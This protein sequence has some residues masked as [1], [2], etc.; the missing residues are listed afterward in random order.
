MSLIIPSFDE[1]LKAAQ[2]IAEAEEPG[3]VAQ[4]IVSAAEN[5][6]GADFATIW[7][8]D[9]DSGKFIP[10]E[11]VAS[12][13]SEKAKEEFRSIEPRPNHLTY[14]VLLKQII[15]IEDVDAGTADIEPSRIRETLRSEGVKSLV[16]I[17]ALAGKRQM[18]VIY[19]A[20]AQP[21]QFSPLLIWSLQG[22]AKLAGLAL[23][24]ER[25]HALTTRTQQAARDMADVLSDR[26]PDRAVKRA[27]AHTVEALNCDSAILYV[28]SE[29][30]DHLIARRTLGR[31]DL[32][33]WQ[34]AIP[35]EF[36]LAQSPK[37]F[38]DSANELGDPAANSCAVEPLHAAGEVVG[39]LIVNYH[40]QNP[41]HRFIKSELDA[42]AVYAHHLAIGLFQ[43]TSVGEVRLRLEERRQL[44]DLSKEFLGQISPSDVLTRGVLKGLELFGEEFCHILLPDKDGDG[45]RIAA[46]AGGWDAKE[47]GRGVPGGANSHA[48]YTAKVQEP[49]ASEDFSTETRF[50]LPGFHK[51]YGIVSGLSAPMI[52]SAKN[53]V[54]VMIVCLTTRHKYEEPAQRLL[55]IL[56]NQVALAKQRSEDFQELRKRNR[57]LI[58]LK[59]ACAAITRTVSNGDEAQTLSQIAKHVAECGWGQ[60]ESGVLTTVQLYDSKRRVLRCAALECPDRNREKALQEL[61]VERPVPGKGITVR[62]AV[63]RKLQIVNDVL[64]DEDYVQFHPDTVAE[65][66]CPLLDENDELLGVLNVESRT[67]FDDN[68]RRTI[69]SFAEVSVIGI[70][71]VRQYQRLQRANRD[72]LGAKDLAERMIDLTYPGFPFWILASS[73]LRSFSLERKPFLT[74]GTHRA[75]PKCFHW[76]LS[77]SEGDNS[78]VGRQFFRHSSE[79]H[80]AASRFRTRE[81]PFYP[82]G[83]GSAQILCSMSPNSLRFRC[84][85][86]NSSQ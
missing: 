41:T 46:V 77:F 8:Y 9:E 22:F 82:L 64:R 37:V 80:S 45:Y 3:R 30:E 20:Y 36:L 34:G 79:L 7:P 83:S 4:E 70:N 13:Y 35:N 18:A 86:A 42:I 75:G 43:R 23:R 5:L 38:E 72:L 28:L 17:V 74:A 21:E 16:G 49:I 11:L 29:S 60:G 68:D 10:R 57:Q 32:E 63:E 52:D 50:E 19:V 61:N 76:T 26:D 65:M 81:R 39:Y 25:L 12:G 51:D 73:I 71:T 1:L 2:V 54:G 55:Q 6:F 40:A 69:E 24:K 59:K 78:S 33:V 66:D 31:A 27:L 84:P 53:V 47:E 44:L 85:S 67:E 15:P 58:S 48:G 56:A 14:T 62:A